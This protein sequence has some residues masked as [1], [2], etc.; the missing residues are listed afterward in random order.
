MDF[1]VVEFYDDA[2]RLASQLVNR[3]KG[4]THISYSS[5][6]SGNSVNYYYEIGDTKKLILSVDL[7]T[8]LVTGNSVDRIQNILWDHKLVLVRYC[9]K[10]KHDK[11]GYVCEST[12]LY[13]ERKKCAIMPFSIETEVYNVK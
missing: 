2:Q 9:G 8:N 11:E 1:D 5:D 10:C 12:P 6:I 13:L 3:L 4:D 7:D